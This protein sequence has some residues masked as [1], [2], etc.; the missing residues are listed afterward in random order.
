MNKIELQEK[1][2]EF[3][4]RTIES[5][6]IDGFHF[7][8]MKEHLVNS[9]GDKTANHILSNALKALPFF[10]DTTLNKSSSKILCLGKVQSGKT[11]FFISSIAL[12][13]D[14]GY[15]VCMLFGGTKNN[16]LDQNLSR[17]YND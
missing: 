14:N 5:I 15:E 13:F 12:A 4:R 16:L 10:A 11:A 2:F 3:N 9:R 6:T 8:K 7:S 1:Q 17:L